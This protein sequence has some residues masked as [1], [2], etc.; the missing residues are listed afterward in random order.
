VAA[1]KKNGFPYEPAYVVKKWTEFADKD[2]YNAIKPPWGTLNAIDLNT[3]EYLWTVPLGEFPE[4][5]AKGIP[6][7]GTKNYGGPVTTASGLIFIAATK[8][9]R[10][11]AFD[12]NT[13]KGSLGVPTTC[14]WICNACYLRGKWQAVRSHCSRRWQG[15]KTRRLVYCFCV[16]VKCKRQLA[17]LC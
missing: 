10:I 13:G 15:Q 11:R 7:T 3:G 17:I 8:D 16:E 2:G 6:I 12:K 5:T 14:G 1:G 4:L 9:E